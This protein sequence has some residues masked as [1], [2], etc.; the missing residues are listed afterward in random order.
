[1]IRPDYKKIH[2]LARKDLGEV[3]SRKQ[4]TKWRKGLSDDLRMMVGLLPRA[5]QFKTEFQKSGCEKPKKRRQTVL[6]RDNRLILESRRGTR[7]PRVSSAQTSL[8][9]LEK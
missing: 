9:I 8:P 1:M 6:G 3:F 7:M 5:E 4:Y 2:E